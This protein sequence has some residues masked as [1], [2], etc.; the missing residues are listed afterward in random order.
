M[1][2]IYFLTKFHV[3][4]STCPLSSEIET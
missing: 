3:P 4:M 2:A 1:Y